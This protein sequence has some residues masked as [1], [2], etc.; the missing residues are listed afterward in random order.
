MTRVK[1]HTCHKCGKAYFGWRCPR[2]YKRKKGS[3]GGG[4][5]RGKRSAAA[6]LWS[7]GFPLTA[8]GNDDAIQSPAP[9]DDEFID[10]AS[11]ARSQDAMIDG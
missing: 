8:R 7:A 1:P 2:C 5:R 11:I 3:G 4:G 9:P 6:V 10:I